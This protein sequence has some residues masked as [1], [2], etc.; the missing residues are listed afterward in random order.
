MSLSI[1]AKLSG[2]AKFMSKL[3]G[4]GN[5]DRLDFHQAL[6]KVGKGMTSYYSNEVFASQGGV[7]GT[8]WEH[9]ADST[10]AYKILHYT[11]Y[12]AVPL[13]ATGAMKDSFT[14][15]AGPRQLVISNSAPYFVYHQSSAPRSKLPRRQMLGINTPI[16]T[17]IKT[18]ILADL[19]AKI[20]SM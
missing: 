6:E 5:L 10:Q 4:L 3:K 17:I 9:L 11:Q 12:A 18:V 16:K 2:D 19:E 14:S 20:G 7:L 15:K 1:E 13:M 8:P